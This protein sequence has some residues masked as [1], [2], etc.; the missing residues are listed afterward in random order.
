MD[1]VKAMTR[2]LVRGANGQLARHTT[3]LFLE[4]TD[5]HLT[6]YLRRASRLKNP[7]ARCGSRR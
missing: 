3:T 6:L 4:R 5:A 2:V 1:S 7:H